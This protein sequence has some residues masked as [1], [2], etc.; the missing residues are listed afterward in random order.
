MSDVLVNGIFGIAG[1][2]IGAIITWILTIASENRGKLRIGISNPAYENDGGTC[3]ISFE[4]VVF[5]DKRDKSGINSCK[6]VVDYDTGTRTDF[7]PVFKTD[8]D[9]DDFNELLNIDAKTFKIA[10]YHKSGIEQSGNTKY[11]F[12]YGLNGKKKIRKIHIKF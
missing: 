9:R 5:N 8:E 11:Y 3:T 2:V 1:A 4:V 10:K 6:V 12:E 7:I